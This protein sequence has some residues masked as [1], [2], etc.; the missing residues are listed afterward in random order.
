MAQQADSLTVPESPGRQTSGRWRLFRR[1]VASHSEPTLSTATGRRGGWLARD[2]QRREDQE[3]EP[4]S[5]ENRGF[6]RGEPSN[7]RAWGRATD[8]ALSAEAEPER[9]ETREQ[10]LRRHAAMQQRKRQPWEMQMQM[11]YERTDWSLYGIIGQQTLGAQKSP[12]LHWAACVARPSPSAQ[13]AT[14][15][16]QWHHGPS[17]WNCC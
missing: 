9:P 16:R 6:G 13:R 14:D 7:R 2:D 5:A 1:W 11:P 4:A 3:G 12:C 8:A 15:T 17:L 10:R